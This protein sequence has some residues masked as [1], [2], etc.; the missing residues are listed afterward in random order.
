MLAKIVLG[1]QQKNFSILGFCIVFFLV[2]GDTESH[3]LD[4]FWF[5]SLDAHRLR[6]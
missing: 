1:S 2:H 5:H 3:I 6:H 4:T